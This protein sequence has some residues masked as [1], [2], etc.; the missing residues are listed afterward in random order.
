MW[1][2]RFGHVGYSGLKKLLKGNLVDGFNLDVQTAKP[3]CVACTEAKQHVEPFPKSVKR[4]TEPGELTHIDVWGKYAIRSINGNQY[5]ILFVDDA[6]R[7]VTMD[8]LKEKSD[9][10][11]AVIIYLAHLITQGRKPKGIQ[12]DCGKEFVNEKLKTWCNERGIE[13]RFTAPYSPSQNGVAERMNRTLVK[14]ARAM[15]NANE[16]PEFLWEYVAL[17]AAYLRNRSYMKHL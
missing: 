2:Q 3:D 1:H 17:H 16:L 7:Y 12:M 10:V 9:A 14:L 4:R 15:I 8:F 11:Q 6:K 5:Y 13:I